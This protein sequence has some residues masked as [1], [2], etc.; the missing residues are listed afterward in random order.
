MVEEY[1]SMVS[2]SKAEENRPVDK[3]SVVYEEETKKNK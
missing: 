3:A 2:K 1:E